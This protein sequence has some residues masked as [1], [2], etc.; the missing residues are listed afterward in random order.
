MDRQATIAC[1]KCGG[2]TFS[3]IAYAHEGSVLEV[4]CP[5]DG[6]SRPLA[7][8]LLGRN[9]VAPSSEPTKAEIAAGQ[10]LDN[11]KRGWQ[12]S[13]KKRRETRQRVVAAFSKMRGT[14]SEKV[15][16]T[17]ALLGVCKKTVWNYLRVE[18]PKAAMKPA[19]WQQGLKRGEEYVAD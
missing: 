1:R 18:H 3:R 12:A 14:K 16:K 11:L 8:S 10:R 7:L 17:A 5:M 4:Y 19:W 15:A 13:N 2:R 6:W 9:P